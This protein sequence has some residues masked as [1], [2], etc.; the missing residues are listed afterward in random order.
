MA[1]NLSN[2]EFTNFL[3]PEM[4]KE[5]VENIPRLEC[6]NSSN[7]NVRKPLPAY[8]FQLY[9]RGLYEGAM[10]AGEF[11]LV[12]LEDFD[13]NI[14][15]I[16]LLHTKSGWRWCK[17]CSVTKRYTHVNRKY[18]VSCDPDCKKCDGTGKERRPQF[19]WFSKSLMK[20]FK[21]F[22]KDNHLNKVDWFFKSPSFPKLA[23]GYNT[24]GERCRE[25]GRL[26]NFN[27]LA[28]YEVRRVRNI[29][30][31]IF[32]HSKAQQMDRD[33]IPIGTI[34]KKLRHSN[35]QITTRYIQADLD[36]AK[37]VEGDMYGW[38]S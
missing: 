14:Y 20:E 11:R 33:G 32:R 5:F 12:K 27:I 3:T 7:P 23:F 37:K 34:S 2:P 21:D 10:R 17:K 13:F 36:D 6:Y 28:R 31:H 38:Y 4:V 25:V 9:I 24:I 22:A 15:E 26:C 16:K 1:Q 8:A 18:L 30:T 19:T 29:Y 35:I